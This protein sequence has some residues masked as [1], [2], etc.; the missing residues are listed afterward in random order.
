ML[1][2]G[3]L[4]IINNILIGQPTFFQDYSI[5]AFFLIVFAAYVLNIVFQKKIVE[6]SNGMIYE[7]EISILKALGDSR[8]SN[9][10]EI[11]KEKIY[12]ILE[13]L[14]SLVFIPYVFINGLNAIFVL[15]VGLVYFF[16]ISFTGAISFLLLVL[17]FIGIYI[18]KNKET[19]RK[20]GISR[21]LNDFYFLLLRDFIDGYKELKLNSLKQAN[22]LN[23]HL[24]P[25]RVKANKME[26]EVSTSFL[27]AN[28]LGQYGMY[29]II[30]VV[31]FLFPKFNLIES[32]QIISFIIVILFI[33]TPINTLASL[34]TF[35][36]RVK[37]ASTRITNFL[38]ELKSKKPL[39]ETTFDKAIDFKS[40]V[41]KDVVYGYENSSFKLNTINTTLFKGET[42]F[43]I[44]GNGSG[45]STF[46]K[47]LTNLY[48]PASGAV[49]LNDE[50]VGVN[51]QKYRDLFSAIFTE[52]HLFLD[53]Y[54]ATD[55]ENNPQYKKLLAIMDLEK[56]IN[57]DTKKSVRRIFSKGQTKRMAMIFALL[58]NRPILVLDEWA[59][60]QDP[61]F[62]RYFYEKLLPKLK[63]E[64]K[65]IIAVTHD[66]RYFKYADRILKFDCGE[67]AKDIRGQFEPTEN[68]SIW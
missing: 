56:V 65:T 3:I 9:M 61:Y 6:M 63:K 19:F 4:Y 31:I 16:Y 46:I 10:E 43:I 25:N 54:G 37:V 20:S 29:V 51:N 44:G 39:A 24:Y 7:N 49:F 55:L 38:A 40:I 13:D 62:R 26:I 42:V 59:A 60:D 2:L 45:K 50:Q 47:L 33:A 18:L 8:L 12:G 11:G 30:G 21:K 17:L 35:Y 14:R 32:G 15:F 28:L 41:F 52:S 67:I 53:N 68:Q 64:G 1:S 58:E 66:D 36:M 34:Q 57:E 27:S 5:F 48:A 23:N 22:I